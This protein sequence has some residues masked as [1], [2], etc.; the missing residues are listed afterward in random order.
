MKRKIF[1]LTYLSLIQ[2]RKNDKK[3]NTNKKRK[4]NVQEK[5]M[6]E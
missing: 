4:H 3:Q 6:F 2:N 1:S 5:K